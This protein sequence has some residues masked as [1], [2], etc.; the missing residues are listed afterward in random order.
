MIVNRKY[1]EIMDEKNS[2][3]T[4]TR[5]GEKQDAK[6]K[7][8]LKEYALYYHKDI[9]SI[10]DMIKRELLLILKTN[11]YLRAIDRRLGSPNNTYNIINNTTWRVYNKEIAQFSSWDYYR[12]LFK[13]YLLKLLLNLQTFKI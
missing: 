10:L 4:K 2:Y 3:R 13:Y 9:V 12:E 7:A 11:N 5:L 8:E 6:S 1:E